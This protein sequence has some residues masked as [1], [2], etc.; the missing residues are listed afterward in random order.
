MIELM[1][2]L[3]TLAMVLVGIAIMLQLAT[4]QDATLFIGR[5]VAAVV[6]MVLALCILKGLWVGVIVP[7][8]SSAFAFLTALMGWFVIATLIALLFIG[9]AVLRRFGRYLP[10]RRDP[11]KGEGY[12]VHDTKE[13]KD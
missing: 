9:P 3:G 5:G 12:E 4:A 13:E 1:T 6:L 2:E 11:L 8:L 10:L 7:W